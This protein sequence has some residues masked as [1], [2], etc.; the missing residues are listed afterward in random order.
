MRVQLE[1][2]SEKL[3]PITT[4]EVTPPFPIPQNSF[5]VDANIQAFRLWTFHSYLYCQP[6]PVQV[7]SAYREFANLI[8]PKREFEVAGATAAL[9][10]FEMDRAVARRYHY[11]GGRVPLYFQS[12]IDSNG[13]VDLLILH[14]DRYEDVPVNPNGSLEDLI[15]H[16]SA[17][18]Q[19]MIRLAMLKQPESE[20]S[21]SRCQN[22]VGETVPLSTLHPYVSQRQIPSLV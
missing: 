18:Y 1:V 13:K 7:Q 14:R 16:E 22:E 5:Q 2:L 17:R 8:V 19:E 6:K 15:N 10:R 4:N 3:L 11:H 20:A 9:E 21:A 12:A